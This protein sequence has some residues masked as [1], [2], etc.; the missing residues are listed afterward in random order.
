MFGFNAIVRERLAQQKVTLKRAGSLV[1]NGTGL[2]KKIKE[3]LAGIPK[4][5]WL[6][7]IYGMLDYRPVWIGRGAYPDRTHTL[8][9]M[10]EKDP[11]L[12]PG[13]IIVREMEKISKFPVPADDDT[14]IERELR[15]MAL[16]HLYAKHHLFGSIDWKAFDNKLKRYHPKGVW[17]PH[18]VLASPV[19]LLVTALGRDTLEEMFT[20]SRPP[21]VIYEKMLAA[22]KKYRKIEAQGGWKRIEA[23]ETLR[24]GKSYAVVPQLRERLAVEGDYDSSLKTNASIKYDATLVEAVKRFQKRHGLS[25]D[26]IVGKRTWEMLNI[27]VE[28]KIAK[29][30]LNLDR[31]KW[32]KRGKER[33]HIIVNIPSFMLYL[34]EGMEPMERMR[35]VVGKKKHE[36]PI[37]YNRIK[38]I[39]LNPYWRIPTSIIKNEMVPKLIADPDYTLKKHIEIHKGPSVESPLVDP[40]SIDWKKYRGKVPPYYFMQSPGSFNALGKIKYLFPNEYAVYMHDTPAKALFHRD[41]RA[42][43]HGCIRLARPVDLLEKYAAIDP[44]IDFDEAR[45][46]L[47]ENRH[48]RLYPKLQIPIDTV[49][50]TTWVTRD[51]IVE[52]RE[53]LYGYDTLQMGR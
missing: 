37:F 50:L 52:F 33:Y 9:K 18:Q 5:G 2:E 40:H 32:F 22:L 35:V 47:D 44:D 34:Y 27:P 12:D 26:G 46:I 39:T 10:I 45:K 23:S 14:V 30:V 43:S 17:I 41:Y 8:L 36:T 49:Y 1:P 13:G 42:F 3:K 11:T 4:N 29:M 15:V 6:R 21:F 48:T 51:G 19:T 20:Y 53:D 25:D 38:R 7:E 28:E 24:P 16:Y 31:I